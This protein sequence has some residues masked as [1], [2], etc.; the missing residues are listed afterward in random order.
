MFLVFLFWAKVYAIEFVLNQLRFLH[1]E[2][3]CPPNMIN[4]SSKH[5]DEVQIDCEDL[6]SS[7]VRV[8]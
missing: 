4:I 7:P 3:T 6:F 5:F 1:V 2:K 8:R